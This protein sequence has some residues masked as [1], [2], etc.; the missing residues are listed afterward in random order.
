MKK[1]IN[2]WLYNLVWRLLHRNDDHVRVWQ[3]GEQ[4]SG[5]DDCPRK[6]DGE[7]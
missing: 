1:R 6:R 7:E 5:C 3:N 4:C 2:V